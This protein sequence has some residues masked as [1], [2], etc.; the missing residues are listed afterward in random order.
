G[1]AQRLSSAEASPRSP[2][3]SHDSDDVRS[4]RT[5]TVAALLLLSSAGTASAMFASRESRPRQPVQVVVV[6][7]MSVDDLTGL[8]NRGAAIGLLV[9]SAGPR[10]SE[11]MAFE[12]MIRGLLYNARV[13]S[14]P[15]GKILIDAHYSR[16]PPG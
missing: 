10:T 1:L 15:R 13:G 3:G 12:A 7:G 9:P 2:Q 8:A 4:L 6:P 14:N 5:L 16:A 11:R